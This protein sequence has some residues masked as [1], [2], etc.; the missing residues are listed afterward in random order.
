MLACIYNNQ[1]PTSF[2]N[3]ID[4]SCLIVSEWER[5]GNVQYGN[6]IKN[7]E[8]DQTIILIIF[9]I[10]TLD[11]ESWSKKIQS[12]LYQKT[13]LCLWVAPAPL[14]SWDLR[15]NKWARWIARWKP[16]ALVFYR[17]ARA[18][19]ARTVKRNSGQWRWSG[20]HRRRGSWAEANAYA[21]LLKHAYASMLATS[22]YVIS[23]NV[24]LSILD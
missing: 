11:Q 6:L 21:Y 15:E 23:V 10:K 22:C 12:L 5:S 16:K 2:S 19:W 20:H 13:H 4:W 8:I 7:I 14:I 1:L 17:R 9:L 3:V 18:Q 24:I